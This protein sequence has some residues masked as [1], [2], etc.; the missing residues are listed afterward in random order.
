M[1]TSDALSRLRA[2]LAAS[3]DAA[4]FALELERP[5]REM[6]DQTAEISYEWVRRTRLSNGGGGAM[7]VDGAP[8]PEDVLRTVAA[9]RKVI[10]EHEP[11]QDDNGGAPF[12][13]TCSDCQ[14]LNAFEVYAD[15]PCATIRAL[16][17]IYTADEI[18]GS[19]P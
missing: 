7:F 8:A 1:T 19:K 15:Y 4:N 5:Y 6:T 2:G 18:E 16:A 14:P 9:I 11:Q 13:P 3:E 12:C 10:A 17:S